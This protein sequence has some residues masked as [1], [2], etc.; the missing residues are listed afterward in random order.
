[1]RVAPG[2]G[3]PWVGVARRIG[4]PS[5]TWVTRWVTTGAQKLHKRAPTASTG[6]YLRGLRA[7]AGP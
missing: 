2:L 4:D 7:Y 1:M 5:V 6:P 3:A